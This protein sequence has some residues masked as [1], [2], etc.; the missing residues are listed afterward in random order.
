[1]PKVNPEEEAV[2]EKVP[3]LE[4]EQ[5]RYLLSLPST[6]CTN[7]DEVKEKLLAVV[8]E[9]EMAPYYK[10]A[11]DLFGW[12]LDAKL[13]AS[14]TESN[15]K[16]IKELDEKILDA[17]ENLGESEIREA[18]VERATFLAQIGEREESEKAYRICVEKSP[19]RGLQLDII[20]TQIRLGFFWDDFDLIKR[21][22]DKAKVILETGGDWERK[23]RLKVY[24][25]LL[26]MSMRNFDEA[27]KLFIDALATFTCY[28]LFSYKKFILYTV[29]VSIISLD[30][31]QLN[32]KVME[33]PEVLSVILELPH[34]NELLNSLYGANYETFF[35]SLAEVTDAMRKD[36][37]LGSHADY[38]CRE[39]RVRAYAQLLESYQS[40]QLSSMAEAFGVSTDFLDKEL[41]RFIA[42]DRLHC[43]IDKIN[44]VVQT[45]RPDAKNALYQSTIKQGDLLLN[46]IQKLTRV[47]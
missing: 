37:Y 5:L 19:S 40:V 26:Q 8:K 21:N 20:L 39:M 22:V 11:C 14:M 24:E 33:S 44:G 7:Q 42:A 34:A 23:N 38:F 9:N 6:V 41:S 46:R 45:N 25:A 28:E 4:L 32:S 47:I 2:V 29:I 31:T 13:H 15:T 43:K 35:T 30:R 17:E 1:M 27:A 12:P 10:H 18:L 3:D 16:R 36:R